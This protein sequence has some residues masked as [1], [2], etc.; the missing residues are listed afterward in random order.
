[1]KEDT[2]IST[3]KTYTSDSTSRLEKF[4]VNKPA[5]SLYIKKNTITRNKLNTSDISL[6]STSIF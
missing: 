1:M 4:L 6:L 5:L 2:I 3:P